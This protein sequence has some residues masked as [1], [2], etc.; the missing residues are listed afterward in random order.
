MSPTDVELFQV[1]GNVGFGDGCLQ[2]TDI[3]GGRYA[4]C[5]KADV[6]VIEEGTIPPVG[7]DY[8]IPQSD[9]A[10]HGQ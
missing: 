1:N 3:K 9:E 8:T 10:P 2:F 7:H 4:V 6:C 5:D